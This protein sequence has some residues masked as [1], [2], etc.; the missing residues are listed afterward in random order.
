MTI[1]GCRELLEGLN[2]YFVT[3]LA[4]ILMI[5]SP[6]FALVTSIMQAQRNIPQ[7]QHLKKETET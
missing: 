2:N 7:A 1:G 4:Q 5:K 6:K 3:S